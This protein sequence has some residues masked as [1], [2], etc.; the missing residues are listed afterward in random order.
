MPVDGAW[1]LV[2]VPAVALAAL[3]TRATTPGGAA[4]GALV[5]LAM[6]AGAGWAGFLMLATMLVLA[7]LASAREERG[8]DWVQV[9]S[10]GSVAAAAAVAAGAGAPWGVAAAGGALATVLS[11]TVSAELGRRFG[12]APRALLLGP[13]L[14]RGADGAMSPLGTLSGV[15]AA[16]P[17]PLVALALGA[18]PDARA[19]LLVAAAGLGGNLLDSVLGLAAQPGLGRRGNDWVNLAATLGGAALGALSVPG[20]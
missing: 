19:A 15:L 6:A 16:L 1:P 13:A 17:V 3:A 4:A 18:L 11:D 7:T 9:L 8:R 14:P 10:N 12:G 5:G 2:A 20:Q